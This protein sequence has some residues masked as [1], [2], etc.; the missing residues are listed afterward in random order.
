MNL[1]SLKFPSVPELSRDCLLKSLLVTT[2]ALLFIGAMTYTI[3]E[4]F[5]LEDIPN[6]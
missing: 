2:I 6:E 3:I 1:K 5:V 4:V